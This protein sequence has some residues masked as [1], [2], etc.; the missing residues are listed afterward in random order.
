MDFEEDLDFNN[1]NKEVCWGFY[2]IFFL[3][4][5]GGLEIVFLFEGGEWDDFDFD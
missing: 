4:I 1:N 3:F 2:L 5:L